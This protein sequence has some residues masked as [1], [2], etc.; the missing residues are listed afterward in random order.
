MKYLIIILLIIG[1]YFGYQKYQSYQEEQNTEAFLE[2]TESSM[3]A[4]AQ[5]L[6]DEITKKFEQNPKKVAPNLTCSGI[7]ATIPIQPRVC[8]QYQG[9]CAQIFQM[10]KSAPPNANFD[11]SFKEGL[12]GCKC[13]LSQCKAKGF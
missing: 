5:K 10:K 6:A 4:E 11:K 13:I 2:K 7:Y 9:N 8:Q 1:G 12:A 3:K